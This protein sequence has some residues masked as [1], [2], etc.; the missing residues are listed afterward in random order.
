[1]KNSNIKQLG[2]TFLLAIFI[3]G[4]SPAQKIVPQ[5]SKIDVLKYT[6]NIKLNDTTNAIEGVAV[7]KVKLGDSVKSISF[8][9]VNEKY[10][11]GMQ[12]KQL[13]CNGKDI[14]FVHQNDLLN[15]GASSL[16]RGVYDFTIV[17]SGIPIDGLIIGRNMYGNRTF[18]CDN[19][20]DRA[21]N[22]FPC[23]DSPLDKAIV[24]FNIT[25]PKKYSVIANGVLKKDRMV[26]EDAKL[27]QYEMISP[28]PT[29]VMVFGVAEFVVEKEGEVGNI[30][31]SDWVY[32]Q[33]KERGIKKF[34]ET[35]NA[36]KF[37]IERIGDYPFQ[38]LASVQSSTIF[39]GM[40]NAGAIFYPENRVA[41]TRSMDETVVHE[42][43]HQWFGNC[44]TETDFSH[45]WLS[46]GF[47]TYLTDLYFEQK[48]GREYFKR[49]LKSQQEEVLYY[50]RQN[51]APVIDSLNYNYMSM[52]NP[53]S[54]E[55]GAWVLHMLRKQ[56]G[57]ELFWKV[58]REYYSEFK[59]GNASTND[60]IKVAEKVSGKK[61]NDFFKQW[62]YHSGHPIINFSWKQEDN[63][64]RLQL[65][66]KQAD[67]FVFKFPVELQIVYDDKSSELISL[68]VKK[69]E[70]LESIRLSKDRK[71]KEVKIDPNVWLL[72]ELN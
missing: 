6:L 9:L 3:I 30:P 55:K 19:W 54:Y 14:D 63:S 34:D 61:L 25:V 59:Y 47:A 50:F 48:F 4:N 1:M 60:F 33:N 38:K 56:I 7:V 52:L 43:A 67:G 44:A 2:I 26:G 68:E 42:I 15:I 22:W 51:N 71:V 29:K 40:E 39:G 17:Y 72:Y 57:D 36:M 62:L 20:P 35:A 37:F 10:S 28:I 53:N 12:V 5:L 69:K 32:P 31:L 18:F 46:E 41:G 49:M 16:K 13:K 66:Q 45:L 23:V 70:F 8:N 58:L 21:Q 24:E 11:K 65:V 27:Y 64:I